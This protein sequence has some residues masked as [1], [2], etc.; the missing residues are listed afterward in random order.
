MEEKKC[1]KCGEVKPLTSEYFHKD[2]SKKDGFVYHCKECAKQQ[3][4]ENAHKRAQR[5]QDNKERVCE[6]RKQYRMNNK[7][8]VAE[9]KKIYNQK[10]KERIA[11]RDK[12]YY[13]KNKERIAERDKLYYQKNKDRIRKRDTKY[14]QHKRTTDKEFNIKD[15]IRSRLKT[16]VK[17]Y[18][19]KKSKNTLEYLGCTMQ[20]Y[21]EHLQQ[22]AI[23]NGYIDF[24]IYDYDGSEYHIDHI[25]PFKAIKD[26][27]TTLEDVCHY[28]NTQILLASVNL[29][30]SDK[31]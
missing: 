27:H 17:N 19:I 11:E 21:M 12:L 20:Q 5:Y 9:S 28:S 8:R 1:S 29:Y 15:K 2:K 24:N 23:D 6:Q 4:K 26:G 30:K 25:I 10:N 14:R 7:K 18:N 3:N 13:Q 31:Y 22:T 16:A